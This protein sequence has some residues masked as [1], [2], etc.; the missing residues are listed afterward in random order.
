MTLQRLDLDRNRFEPLNGPWNDMTVRAFDVRPDGLQ[1]VWSAA[2]GSQRDDLWVAS[3]NGGVATPL[4]GADD[5]SRK[6]LPLWNGLG[7]TVIYQSNRGG[8]VDLWELVT[9]SRQSFRR[10]SNPGIERPESTLK[11]GSMSYQLTSQK[12]ALWIWNV[13][14]GK[15]RQ[16]GD[17]GLSDFAPS[18][19]RNGRLQLV[20]QRS[21]PSPVEG[22]LQM[23]SDIYLADVT[24][25]KARL[26]RA[27]KVATGLAPQLSPDAKYLAYLQRGQNTPGQER[28]FVRNLNTSAVDKLSSNLLLPANDNF[29]VAWI[30]QNMAWA[31][32]EDLYFVKRVDPPEVWRLVHYRVGS[33][34]TPV[35][36]TKAYQPVSDHGYLPVV[37]WQNHRLSQSDGRQRD[38]RL[39]LQTSRGGPC[40]RERSSCQGLGVAAW[41]TSSRLASKGRGPNHH[42][43]CCHR[44]RS[45]LDGRTDGAPSRWHAPADRHDRSRSERVSSGFAAVGPVFHTFCGRCGEPLCLFRGRS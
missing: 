40:D 30:E 23:D 10:S 25:P 4:T 41:P 8:Q 11:D 35:A 28:L 37:R 39:D 19:S 34:P 9:K 7:T 15:G 26:E 24:N 31:S 38:G 5:E 13:Q 6:R 32:P 20:F 3:I 17:E 14:D 21:L 29:P 42:S 33:A 43:V 22:F 16:V 2:T 1:V 44:R 18:V 45:H 27:K 36:S 12:T